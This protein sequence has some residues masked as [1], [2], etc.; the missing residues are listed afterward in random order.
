MSEI[1]TSRFQQFLRQTFGITERFAPTILED[2]MPVYPIEDPSEAHLQLGKDVFTVFGGIAVT[3][4]V[5]DVAT[6]DLAPTQ[7]SSRTLLDVVALALSVTGATMNIVISHVGFA[8]SAPTVVTPLTPMDGR[9]IGSENQPQRATFG[10]S[11]QVAG[12]AA[13]TVNAWGVTIPATAG[14]I[15]PFKATLYR[16]ALRFQGNV[17]NVGMRIGV[18]GQERTAEPSEDRQKISSAP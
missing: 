11:A 4:A 18:I 7:A 10:L 5:T 1:R 15:V 8:A 13:A 14:I 6:V 12:F 16:S 17:V 9:R 3:P 2:V